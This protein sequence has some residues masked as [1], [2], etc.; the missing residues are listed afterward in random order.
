LQVQLYAHASR[1]V[2]G[3]DTKTGAVHLL[4]GENAEGFPNRVE[5]PVSDEAIASAIENIIWAVNQI[6]TGDFPRRPSKKKCD[7]CDFK[8]ICSKSK[9]NFVNTTLPPEIQIPNMNGLTSIMVRAFSD[10]IA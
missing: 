2:L 4:K 6:L 1:I 7:E 3:E 10:V 9:E 8:L 5:V